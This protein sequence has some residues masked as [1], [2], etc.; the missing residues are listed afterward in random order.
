M[1]SVTDWFLSQTKLRKFVLDHSYESVSWVFACVQRISTAASSVPYIFTPEKHELVSLLR[2]PE[3][4]RIPSFS[5]LIEITFMYMEL[6]GGCIWYWEDEDSLRI[7]SIK[8]VSPMMDQ[9]DPT[10]LIGWV[11]YRPDSR[12]PDKVIS[13]SEVVPFIYFNP[14]NPL[15]GLSPLKPARLGLEQW[16]NM[17]AWNAAFFESGIR[18]PLV[19]VSKH[20]LTAEQEKQIQKRLREFYAGLSGGHSA[21]IVDGEADV[22]PLNT[23]AK[24]L[25]FIEGLQLSREE[26]CAIF[27]V[28]P[29][30]VGIYR[31]AN[32]AN[33]KEQR[34]IFWEQ[35][36]LPKLRFVE[37]MLNA[38][39]EVN[40]REVAFEWD[41]SKIEALRPDPIDAARAAEIYAN[42]GYSRDQIASILNIPQLAPAEETQQGP[43]D[44]EDKTTYVV[45]PRTVKLSDEDYAHELVSTFRIYE[46]KWERFFRVLA[47]QSA[48]ELLLQLRRRGEIDEGLY[49]NNAQ[50]W[51]EDAE[52]RTFE[53]FFVSYAVASREVST[54]RI[55]LESGIEA[56]LKT[57]DLDAFLNTLD[58]KE[59]DFAVSVAREIAYKTRWVTDMVRETILQVVLA[60]LSTGGAYATISEIK[61]ELYAFIEERYLGRSLTIARTVSGAA[62]NAGRYAVWQSRG[63]THHRWI[64][65]RDAEVRDTHALQH[66]QVVRI[67]EAFQNGLLYPH[68][69]NGPAREVINC[70]CTTT[71]VAKLEGTRPRPVK[72]RKTDLR[73][74]Y[75]EFILGL[76]ELVEVFKD[77]NYWKE[78]KLWAFEGYAENQ[79]IHEADKAVTSLA[80]VVKDNDFQNIGKFIEENRKNQRVSLQMSASFKVSEKA[81]DTFERY[82]GRLLPKETTEL[83]H[84]SGLKMEFKNINIGGLYRIRENKI[85]LKLTKTDV[86]QLADLMRVSMGELTAEELEKSLVKWAER[87]VAKKEIDPDTRD[88][89]V[90]KLV[91]DRK[92]WLMRKLE[93]VVHEY[94]HAVH[95]HDP[96]VQGMVK[97]IYE[98][99]VTEKTYRRYDPGKWPSYYAGRVYPRPPV[100]VTRGA[101]VPSV[102][103]EALAVV[104]QSAQG[105]KELA[106][107][108]KTMLPGHAEISNYRSTYSF[109]PDFVDYWFEDIHFE[110]EKIKA[111]RTGGQ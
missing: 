57:F 76:E 80:K 100:G 17:S 26:I 84:H 62:L 18:A 101:E 28:P 109:I 23:S 14:R 45:G 60:R 78:R 12:V 6:D 38:F 61:S 97:D 70:R 90:K 94:G 54:S 59:R 98:A 110:A 72:P 95:K 65:A 67:G 88:F 43:E 42:L 46:S 82:L 36:M 40:G 85:V 9:K 86:E 5:K 74:A 68:D 35:T 16:F 66:G 15:H 8:D 11:R 96:I 30:L 106:E 53:E 73:T 92:G 10:K 56:H 47:K 13:P 75:E 63:V 4:P 103:F 107:V 81:Q 89:I 29:A 27:G 41:Y 99:R 64:T 93:T 55:K 24:E 104:P 50:L 69:P 108:I 77:K 58:L 7:L 91:A 49:R 79:P 31:Y 19:L 51:H 52:Q 105:A 3:F 25:D 37:E 87:K 39:F 2:R 32:Y 44:S 71:P 1:R 20:K 83:L 111:K 34:K 21:L 48:D 102:A 22:K 33:T